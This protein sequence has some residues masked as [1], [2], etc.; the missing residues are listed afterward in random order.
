MQDWKDAEAFRLQYAN[1][2][3]L[4]ALFSVKLK[5]TV[6]FFGV[7]LIKIKS[8]DAGVRVYILGIRCL[9]IKYQRNN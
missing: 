1:E 9:E 4:E 8:G 7:P 6:K 2:N 3:K 5:K